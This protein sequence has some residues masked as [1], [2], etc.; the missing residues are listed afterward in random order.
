METLDVTLSTLHL[1]RTGAAIVHA[2]G[3][4]RRRGAISEAAAAYREALAVEP[5]NRTAMRELASTLRALGRHG[6][7]QE[8][9]AAHALAEADA[10]FVVAE[11][12]ACSGQP[13]RADAYL[14]Q[15]LT[16]M[17][18]HAAALF[19][20]GALDGAPAP[21]AAPARA[22]AL[23]YD[24]LAARYDFESRKTLQRRA[25]LEVFEMA[26][27]LVGVGRR[28]LAIADVGCG[29]GLCAP[30]F[31]A[32]HVAID[33][34][35]L[36]PS[37]L[38]RAARKMCYRSLDE[39]DL[40]HWLAGRDADYDLVIASEAFLHTGSLRPVF[41]AAATALR[42][43]GV[44]ICTVDLGRGARFD[45][46]ANGRYVHGPFYVRHTAHEAG[47]ALVK[48]RRLVLRTEESG[49][50]EG[51]VLAFARSNAKAD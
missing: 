30:Y 28:A 1:P 34:V 16:Q 8:A 32:D 3:M 11:R 45:L 47:L 31:Q 49:P 17:P 37:M 20:R 48:A 2:A 23:V 42:R 50:V 14:D 38:S 5:G 36:S 39:G 12:C 19:L 44:F 25:P 27:G 46:R 6:E 10:A 7:A 24:A 4:M 9:Q 33:G 43:E 29:S 21:D 13:D 51:E 22:V 41:T 18:T 26:S 40:S 35:D 15:C